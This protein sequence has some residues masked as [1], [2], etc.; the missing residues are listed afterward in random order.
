MKSWQ[1]KV[2]GKENYP[3]EDEEYRQEFLQ[4]RPFI[5]RRDRGKC[6]SCFK[7]INRPNY[8]VHH[9]ISR[10]KGGTNGTSN[11]ILLCHECHNIIEG[12]EMTREQI[13][14]Y[15]AKPEK[16]KEYRKTSWC[17][18]WHAWVYGSESNPYDDDE[19][20]KLHSK[21]KL[22]HLGNHWYLRKY[23]FA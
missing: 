19:F 9:I 3:E 6:Q 22:I 17:A 16:F 20:V 23:S 8:S 13:H 7:K 18:D 14:G 4:I 21:G 12:K 5:Y 15:L 11:L 10:K 2:Y 1:E